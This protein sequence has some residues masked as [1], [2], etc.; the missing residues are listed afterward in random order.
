VS[1]ILWRQHT[2]SSPVAF[3]NAPIDLAVLQVV[4][5]A[6]G[7]IAYG[8]YE[9]P[10]YMVH[11]G[12]FIPPIATRSGIP[13]V[14]GEHT[15]SFTLF[16]PSGP[17]PAGGWPVSIVTHSGASNQHQTTGFVASKMA[18]YGIATIGINNFGSGFGPLGT[19]TVNA[20]TGGSLTI[21]NPGRG[22]DQNGDGTIGIGE[23]VVAAPPR[24]WTIQERDG[25]RQTVADLLQLVRVVE[26]GMDVDG[27]GSWD[28]DPNRIY[29]HG[30][31]FGARIATVFMAL[32]PNVAA[33]VHTVS[34]G[35]SP[36]H[37]RWA[38]VRRAM[39]GPMLQRRIPSLINAP[40]ILSIEGVPVPAPHFNEN[41]PARDEAPRINTIP[42]AI[43]IQQALELSEM[44][45]QSGVSPVVWARHIRTEPLAGLHAKSVIFQSAEC[46]QTA[47]AM[48][49]AAILRAGDVA[50]AT[51]RY[52]HDLAFAADPTIPKNPHAVLAFVTSPNLFYRSI[53]RGILDQ[54]GL[55]LASGGSV[56]IHPEPAAFFE[57]PIRSPLPE[58]LNFIQ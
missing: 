10:D 22:I 9:S 31:S 27:D 8:S 39:L 43:E 52:R 26:G 16:L 23:G 4:P 38:P 48:G 32:E 18:S 47:T 5:G 6:V 54:V 40:G 11:P 13:V 44:A 15:V 35:L 41:K 53:A 24:A 49:T 28:I 56:V 20:T 12:E 57:V 45:S 14:Q 3:T 36:E 55:F 2:G 33:A 34:G 25:V 46:D 58:R 51:L 37:D 50:D 1:S 30:I 17:P 19:L 42:G 7:T 21:P 29:F